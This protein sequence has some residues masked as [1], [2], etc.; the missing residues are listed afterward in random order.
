MHELIYFSMFLLTLIRVI[1]FIVSVNFYY[2]SKSYTYIYFTIGWC[3]WI[4]AGIVALLSAVVKNQAQE[5]VF[6]LINYILGPLA[7]F[8]LGSG[9]SSYYIN[10]SSNKIKLISAVLL[11]FPL[12]INFSL[13]MNPV[14]IYARI[15]Q[16][17][18]I[19]QMF[20]LPFLKYNTFKEKIGKSIRWYYLTCL[21]IILY[22]PLAILSMLISLNSGSFQSQDITMIVGAYTSIIIM[23]IL[24]IAF[25]IHLEYT[26]S[27]KQQNQLKDKYSHNLG[28]IM[29]VIY[30]SA[31]LFKRITK[32]DKIDK[33]KLDLIERKCKEASELI[34]EIRKI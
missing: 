11:I 31:D 33:D 21:S 5:D 2:E 22:I 32:L 12:I 17:F 16:F 7:I 19:I 28:N 27:N 26:I 23:T 18:G 24:V 1:G 3:L 6:L 34:K 9:L 4:L 8:F 15:F 20:S 29:Q 10:I 13:G 25:I 14:A 30:S